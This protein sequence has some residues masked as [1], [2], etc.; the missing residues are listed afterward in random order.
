MYLEDSLQ[1][2]PNDE[3]VREGK[4]SKAIPGKVVAHVWIISQ[5]IARR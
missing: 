1:A 5:D 4:R 2:E 3:E